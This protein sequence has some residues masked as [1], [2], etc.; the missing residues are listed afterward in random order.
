L[1]DGVNEAI[2]IS[3]AEAR[4][5]LALE[6]STPVLLSFGAVHMGKN[7]EVVLRASY[8]LN[9]TLVQAGRIYAGRRESIS[10]LTRNKGFVLRDAYISESL[11]PCYFSAASAIVLSYAKDFDGTPSMLWEA[12]KYRVPVLASNNKQLERL[13]KAYGVGLVFDAEN[14]ESLRN[15]MKT[16]LNLSSQDVA[17]IKQ[18][19]DKFLRA[20]SS[21]VWLDQCETI[22][23]ALMRSTTERGR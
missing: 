1:T 7:L 21:R 15:T 3:A 9:L 16:F 19:C 23:D 20:F 11:K 13:V 8:G 2:R 14:E 22:Y 18:N 17:T 10:E 4:S 12:C 5:R 6:P